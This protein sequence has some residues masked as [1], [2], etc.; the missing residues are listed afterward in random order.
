M[1]FMKLSLEDG[2]ALVRLA[3]EALEE[4]FGGR[5]GRKIEKN[6]GKNPADF[7]KRVKKFSEKRG[8]FVTLEKNGKLRGCIGYPLPVMKLYDAVQNAA[9]HAANDPRFAPLAEKELSEITVEITIL[10]VPELFK[11]NKK[12]LPAKIHIGKHGLMIE[13]CGAS[14]LLLPQVATGQKWGAEEF[15]GEVCWKAGLEPSAWLA[16][17]AK[18]YLFEGQIFKEEKP[19]G[20]VAEEKT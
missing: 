7:E 9:E 11:G 2:S 16:P 18:V 20:K 12:D 10:S 5:G 1:N 19:G 13:Y 15:L 6:L 17:G 4:K 14:G 3:R 8:V